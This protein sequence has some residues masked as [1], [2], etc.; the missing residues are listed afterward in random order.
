MWQILPESKCWFDYYMNTYLQQLLL[1]HWVL[2]N[3][4]ITVPTVTITLRVKEM[5]LLQFHLKKGVVKENSLEKKFKYLFSIKIEFICEILV[6]EKSELNIF[7]S[8]PWEEDS[9]NR[10]HCYQENAMELSL[11]IFG[12]GVSNCIISVSRGMW[13]DEMI[14]VSALVEKPVMSPVWRC[15][16]INPSGSK[17][18]YEIPLFIKPRGSN[19]F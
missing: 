6:S 17:L 11:E 5:R 10:T 16:S 13:K 8:I 4:L 2:Y 18:E 3:L 1:F 14:C 9:N 19:V 12:M 15:A 7:P